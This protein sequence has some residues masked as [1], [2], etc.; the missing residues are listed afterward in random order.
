MT[1]PIA[2]RQFTAGIVRSFER[3]RVNGPHKGYKV[4]LAAL[5]AARC[6]TCSRIQLLRRIQ[7]LPENNGVGL[8]AARNPR[9]DISDRD[10]R[11]FASPLRIG[12]RPSAVDM[13]AA[14][15]HPIPRRLLDRAAESACRSCRY[16]TGG[17]G[18]ASDVEPV[19]C[20]SAAPDRGDSRLPNLARTPLRGTDRQNQRRISAAIGP[21]RT[22]PGMFRPVRPRPTG[23][24]RKNLAPIHTLSPTIRSW[25]AQPV[26]F[27]SRICATPP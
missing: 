14:L 24:G 11:L 15:R 27:T 3:Y 19:P 18:R 5:H 21:V 26:Q 16:S 12:R 23:T 17:A 25:G 4:G 7:R 20:R 9:A 10:G 2:S 6:A 8:H 13:R 22:H 1:V